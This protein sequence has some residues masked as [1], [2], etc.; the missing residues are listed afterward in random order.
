MGFTWTSTTHIKHKTIDL[1]KKTY[2]F[3]YWIVHIVIGYFNL[4][5]MWT[6]HK[7]TFQFNYSYQHFRMESLYCLFAKDDYMCQID[8]KDAYFSVHLHKD[9]QKLVRF[10]WAGSMYKSFVLKVSWKV[11][12]KLEMYEMQGMILLDLTKLFG[13]LTSAIQAILPERLQFRY[14]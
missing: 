3:I 12:W 13:T 11:Y 4:T 2:L 5:T 1:L 8:L 9:S 6:I 7:L 14:L 10:Q